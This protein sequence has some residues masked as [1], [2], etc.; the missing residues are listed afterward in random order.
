MVEINLVF[1]TLSWHYLVNLETNAVPWVSHGRAQIFAHSN[2]N[3]GMLTQSAGQTSIA[4]LKHVKCLE[5]G[6]LYYYWL[7]CVVNLWSSEFISILK[8]LSDV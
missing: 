1:L 2:R 6:V 4:S 8:A 7:Q 3:V 5:D